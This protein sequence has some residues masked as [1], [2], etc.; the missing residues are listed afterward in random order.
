MHAQQKTY[1]QS[2]LS[3]M[4]RATLPATRS[5]NALALCYAIAFPFG[6]KVT[7]FPQFSL[8]A[9]SIHLLAEPFQ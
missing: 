6:H 2:T 3:A 5:L 8:D 4:T 7:P 9:I 1:S